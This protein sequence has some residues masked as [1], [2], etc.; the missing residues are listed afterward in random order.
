MTGFEYCVALHLAQVSTAERR[1]MYLARAP[2][3]AF[4]LAVGREL[5]IAWPAEG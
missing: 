2:G 3:V 5:G 1:R 4:A